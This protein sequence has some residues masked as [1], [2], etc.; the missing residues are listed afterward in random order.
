MFDATRS[1]GRAA[2]VARRALVW[3]TALALLALGVL[4]PLGAGAPSAHILDVD[5][6]PVDTDGNGRFEYLNVTAVLSPPVSGSYL[7]AATLK[8]PQ[9][10]TTVAS[11]S[12]IAVL[13]SGVTPYTMRLDG[14][15]INEKQLD[16]PYNLTVDLLSSPGGSVADTASF[17]TGPL[18]AA[19]FERSAERDKPVLAV[20]DSEVHLATPSI[21]ATVNLTSPAVR[22]GTPPGA[23]HAAAFEARFPQLVAFGDDGDHAYETGENRCAASLASGNW[24]ITALEIGP[25]AD[26]GSYIRFTM[27]SWVDFEGT[28]CA[29][30]PEG[31]LMLTFLITQRN[32][33]VNGTSPYPLLGGLEV[34]VDMRLDLTTA[35][36]TSD[37]AFEVDL[38][39]Q[40][41]SMAFLVRGPDGFERIVPSPDHGPIVPLSP[42]VPSEIERVSF[43]DAAGVARGHFAWLSLAAENLTT[44]QERFV[45]VAASRSQ[46][47]G[48]LHL[49]L[50][51][52]NDAAL[53][54]V[55]LD[56][57]VG[58]PAPPPALS[59]GNA[60]GP[61]LPEEAPSVL[62]FVGAMAA[63]S[64]IFFFSIYARAKKR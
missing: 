27:G 64:A 36:P 25:S 12:S 34:K 10:G 30:G 43:L 44:G 39:E 54:S 59:G 47:A 20:G 15:T 48:A 26:W 14:P 5:V 58:V 22:W 3:L 45:Q 53:H 61:Q 29:G 50:A 41:R 35:L 38:F 11:V 63:T 13:P 37:L 17:P 51:V 7:V 28:P 40:T 57:A 60:T 31:R 56:P 55:L 52:P 4:A 49:Y 32:A 21:N 16:G 6:F 33:T 24:T 18:R 42:A 46:D 8:W 19:Q 2:A 62:V 23:P 9:T 1:R